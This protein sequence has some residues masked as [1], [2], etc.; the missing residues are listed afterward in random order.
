MCPR[1]VFMYCVINLLAGAP[2][3]VTQLYNSSRPEREAM[4]YY[5][6]E[7]LLELSANPSH[8]SELDFSLWKKRTRL[9]DLA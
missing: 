6:M 1:T 2:L 7:S 5:T 8:L 9:P 3:L 4:E